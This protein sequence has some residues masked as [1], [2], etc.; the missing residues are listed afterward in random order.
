MSPNAPGMLLSVDEEKKRLLCRGSV[1][2]R[3]VTAKGLSA[4][5]W[6]YH[7]ADV[8]GGK[9]GEDE[10]AQA[11]QTKPWYS[12]GDGRRVREAQLKV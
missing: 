6:V 7:L 10:S 4:S 5:E 3:V 1:R 9:G 11:S 2:K 8:I 12:H